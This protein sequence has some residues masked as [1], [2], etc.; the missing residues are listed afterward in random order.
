MRRF[1]VCSHYCIRST[2]PL[3]CD[4][5]AGFVVSISS[6]IKCRRAKSFSTSSTDH[7][8][9]FV[10]NISSLAAGFFTIGFQSFSVSHTCSFLAVDKLVSQMCMRVSSVEPAGHEQSNM[11]E[12]PPFR[13]F[14]QTALLYSAFQLEPR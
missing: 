2:V 9:I 5:Q 10:L 6:V 14:Y 11:P 1:Y 7:S 12:H 13:S 4:K 3:M 8:L